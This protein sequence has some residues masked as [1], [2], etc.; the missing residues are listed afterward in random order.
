LEDWIRYG[1]FLQKQISYDYFLRRY[2]M[3]NPSA[4]MR[5]I[6]RI[7]DNDLNGNLQLW[8][9]LRRIKGIGFNLAKIVCR[10]SDIGEAEKIGFLS[11]SDVQKINNTIK[12]LHQLVPAWLLNL[13]GDMV[14][15]ENLHFVNNDLYFKIDQILRDYKKL[16]NYKGI[17]HSY[18]L[19][20]RGQRTKSNF[21]PSK[22]RKKQVK[23]AK[24][25][26]K[27]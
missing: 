20:V 12:N 8:I 21:R 7:A 16:K 23:K 14:T 15:G 26:R 10:I 25:A 3:E 22:R 4:K 24:T 19:P 27:H 13:Q 5:H 18:H 11:D 17:R 9:G 6:V 1:L 2:I